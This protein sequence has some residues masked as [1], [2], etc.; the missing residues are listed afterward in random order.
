[1]FLGQY[2]FSVDK[3]GRVVIP[4]KFRGL[5][6]DGAY[7]TQGF[8]RNLRV[9]TVPAFKAIFDRLSRMNIA[10]P[11][12]RQLRRLIFSNANYVQ[13]DSAGRI[14]IP[15]FLRDVA[16]LSSEA[17]IV[18]VGDSLEIWSPES[19]EEQLALLQDADANGQ[20]YSSLDL[21]F[22]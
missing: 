1:M 10:D 7:V 15:Q 2:R 12:T 11:T 4:R 9:L 21:S 20:R 8:E 3:K 16:G 13:L 6:G 14:L 17:V 22:D 5:L 18:G 19:W